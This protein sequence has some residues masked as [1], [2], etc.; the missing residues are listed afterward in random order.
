MDP[1]CTPVDAADANESPRFQVTKRFLASAFGAVPAARNSFRDKSETLWG[2]LE[3]PDAFKA[4]CM[5]NNL[6]IDTFICETS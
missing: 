6:Q 2:G 5:R 1:R 4:R 3:P